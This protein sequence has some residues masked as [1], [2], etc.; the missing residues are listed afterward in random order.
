MTKSLDLHKIS[1]SKTNQEAIDGKTTG[2]IFLNEFV[3]WRAK[4]FGFTQN[5]TSIIS[6]YERPFLF[7]DEQI[8][9]IFKS[10][11]RK[12][13][14]EQIGEKVIMKD[15][16]IF[17]TTFGILGQIFNQI[18]L[19]NYMRKFLIERNKIIKEFTETNKWKLVLK[20]SPCFPY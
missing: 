13:L 12:H 10:F 7:V 2:L 20:D 17:T 14:F 6:D 11:Y 8:K 18:V 16:F 5:L 15:I 9:G 1:T 19:T 4:H 3:T